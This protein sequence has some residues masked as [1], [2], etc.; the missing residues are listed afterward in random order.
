MANRIVL[1]TD[2]GA[3]AKLEDVLGSRG[4][5][6][7]T[8]QMRRLYKDG[9]VEELLN[10]QTVYKEQ[11]WQ[12]MVDANPQLSHNRSEFEEA[13]RSVERLNNP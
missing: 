7:G 5:L 9:I 13:W 10:N 1:T 3:N 8:L 2:K 11:I 12:I 6:R 4:T